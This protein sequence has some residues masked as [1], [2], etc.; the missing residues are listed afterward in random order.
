MAASIAAMTASL[1]FKFSL[2]H[3]E[4]PVDLDNLRCSTKD[5]LVDRLNTA[6]VM[7]FDS[8]RSVV[9]LM[10]RLYTPVEVQARGDRFMF[11]FSNERDVNGVKKGEPSGFQHALILLNDYD[12]FFDIMVVPP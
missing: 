9:R 8:F 3:P 11:T 5:N 10:W 1:A 12:G 6:R 4:E 2:G 7:A